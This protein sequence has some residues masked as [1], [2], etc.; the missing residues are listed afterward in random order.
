MGV[1][2]IEGVRVTV[3]DAVCVG[4]D[5]GEVVEVANID[6]VTGGK[7]ITVG[8][9]DM[10][11]EVTAVILVLSIVTDNVPAGGSRQAKNKLPRKTN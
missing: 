5:V 8:G 3:G 4:W 6:W 11:V 7:G 10:S 2:V 1:G 9:V